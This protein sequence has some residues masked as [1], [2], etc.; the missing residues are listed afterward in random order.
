MTG[1]SLDQHNSNAVASQNYYP[2]KSS[3][4]SYPSGR[5]A[6]VRHHQN[7]DSYDHNNR[8]T[9]DQQKLWST[10]QEREDRHTPKETSTSDSAIASYLQ[11]PSSIN[12]S[13]GSLAEFA[14]EVG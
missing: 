10:T 6:D 2:S 8:P 1:I 14:A 12:N 13:R 7:A 5:G 11:I 9:E 4:S 3:Y